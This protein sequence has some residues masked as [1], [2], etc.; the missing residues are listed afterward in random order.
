MAFDACLAAVGQ[1]DVDMMVAGLTY[2]E[3]RL[4]RM[5]LTG[6]Y[7]N[8]GD[9]EGHGRFLQLRRVLRGQE[10]RRAERHQPAGH[11]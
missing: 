2:D 3:A 6:I 4:N 1:G 10:C 9:Q 5:E 8:E 11:G 7:W